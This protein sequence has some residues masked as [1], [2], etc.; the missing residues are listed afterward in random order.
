MKRFLA[1]VLCIVLG[2]SLFQLQVPEVKAGYTAL[3]AFPGAE[4]FGYAAT[5]GRGGEVYHV[6]SY[7]LTGPGTFHDALMSAGT[8]PRTIVFDISGEITI[9]QIVVRNKSKITIAGQTAPGD[10]V[11]IRGNNIRFIDCSDIVIRYMRF[12]LGVQSF[13][14][15]TMYFEDCQNV[16]I[17]HSSF[18]WGTDE[19]LSIKSKDYDNPESKNITVQWSII[20]EGLL[21]HSMG[22]LIEMNT[23]TMHHNI[24]AHNND[25]NPKTKGQID[26]VNNIVYNWGQFPY[27]AGGESGTKGYGNVVGN[28]FIA[29]LNSA[30]PHYAIVRG[31]E[32]Y[33]LYLDN[34]R[35]D[36]NKNGIL[37]GTD[38]GT[39]MIEVERPSVVVPERYEYPPV[40]TQDP[41]IAYNHVLDYAG[42]SLVRDAADRRV[43]DDVRNQTGVIIGHENDV[44]GFPVLEQVT[45]PAD[46]DRDGMPDQWE[47]SKGLDPNNPEDRNG[48][49]NGDGYTNLEH[50]L[51]ELA[52]PGF[53]A[54]Y[55]SVPPAW[56]GTPFE[57]PVEPKPEPVSEPKPSMDGDILRNVVINDNSSNGD[58]NESNWS[59]QENL[60]VGDPVA[61]DRLTGT[62]V[63]KFVSIPDEL[64]G[65]EWIRSAVNS[66]SATSDNLV[67]FY[68]AADADV[69][70]AY[71]SRITTPPQWLTSSYEDTGL[72]IED[73]QPVQFK[74][75]KKNYSAASFVVMGPNNN[76][77]RMNYFVIIKPSSPQAEPPFDSPSGLTGT[78]SEDLSVSL[79]WSPVS[80]AGAYLI[81]RSSSMDP[82]FKVIGSSTTA[83]YVDAAAVLGNT[84]NYKVSALNA[85]GESP[86][87]ENIEVSAF[88][89]TQ[90]IPPAPTGLSVPVIKSISVGLEWTP[91]EDALSYGI[92]RES[93]PEGPYNK[94]GSSLTAAY[95]D[96][97]VSPSTTYYYKVSATGVGGESEKS[98]SVSTTTNP[99]VTIPET[100]TG[101]SA[102]TVTTSAF[103]ILWKPVDNAESYNIYRKASGES[104]FTLLG[105]T[106]SAVYVDKKISVSKTGYSYKVTAVNE[107]GESAQSD[108]AAVAMPLP[109]TPTNLFVGLKGETFVGLIWTSHGGAAQYNIYRSSAGEEAQY[110]GYAKVDTYYDRT[111]EPGVEY[112]YYIKAQNASGESEKSNSVIVKTL[113]TPKDTT[114]PVTT[115]DAKSGW[116]NT[117]QT[118]TFSTVDAEGSKTSTYYSINDGPFVSG[119]QAV[120]DEEGEYTLRYYSV[121]SAGNQEAVKSAAVK[122][123]L[124]GP[125]VQTTVTT[126]VYRPD[127]VNIPFVITDS[128]SGVDKVEATLDGSV[129]SVPLTADPYSL[130]IGDH[131]IVVTA[132]D[133]A[134][135]VTVRHYVLKVTMDHG[136]LDE[137]LRLAYGKGWITNEG[138]LDSLLDKVQ[139]LQ[140]QS[141]SKEIINALNALEKEVSAL[142]GRQIDK[143]FAGH[144]LADIAYLKE[145]I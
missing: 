36:S 125:I 12:R 42:A 123:D 75:Y 122:I 87:S 22:G 118:V 5:G 57:P 113:G 74:L 71:D 13:K 2:F 112:T 51:N 7:E 23:I 64:K 40:H 137:A 83:Q 136:Y 116:Q 69:Y 11:T 15:D 121:D 56:S 76:T 91:V 44:G 108:E 6:T 59:V 28:Y 48:D 107:M 110:V 70:V 124:T 73:D 105:S 77:S 53:P 14:D 45:A 97:T 82:Y 1:L 89:T 26:F 92:Y 31:N 41:E 49:M 30:D 101:V 84:Y 65:M 27:V 78:M 90:P 143:A 117:A 63:Y 100:P 139:H 104:T 81:Y 72:V 120:I 140:N 25:R 60:Q 106:S 58:V 38:T 47:L 99:P 79:D 103:E 55:P 4:G 127:A 19:V 138:V 132:T 54:N 115:T 95:T 33:S 80:G 85:G 128:L 133:N 50:Y 9:P 43:I 35:I 66:R 144:L 21:T 119:N 93:D 102:G 129:A 10:G 29:G 94:I 131:P 111:V 109:S 32:N 96:K 61:G 24:Y 3:P 126:T 145:Q 98:G 68:L 67:S 16:I 37:D 17:D 52:A 88:D 86:Q 46:T 135:N 62:R 8:T 130:P 18:S 39:G 141:D 142:A 20:S 34:N 134:G 114:A